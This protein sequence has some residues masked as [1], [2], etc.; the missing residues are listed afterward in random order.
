MIER[1]LVHALEVRHGDVEKRQGGRG[2][3]QPGVRGARC[4]P[5]TLGQD[6][7]EALPVGERP[8]GRVGRHQVVQVG[9][10][11][12]RQ[13]ADDDRG[14]DAL[15]E[16]LGVAPH[17]VL[18]EEAVL[19]QPD[20]E[21]VLLEDA[22]AVESAFVAHRSAQKLEPALEVRCAVVV[23]LGL[24]CR[25]LHQLGRIERE[26]RTG[27]LHEV[28]D[29]AHLVGVTRLGQVVDADGRR[30]GVH[31]E[32]TGTTS[33]RGCSGVSSGRNQRNQMR[34]LR[35]PAVDTQLGCA[36]RRAATTMVHEPSGS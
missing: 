32:V 35:W 23:E 12:P 9:G 1:H 33:T 30:A 19:E 18:D 22:G 28:E 36:G 34:P 16:D 4:G 27:L 31:T 11:G 6:G 15:L 5:L 7:L 14:G 20:D 10:A 13:A 24:R 17:H 21:G 29:R 26:V 25:R 2:P 8:Q 3:F